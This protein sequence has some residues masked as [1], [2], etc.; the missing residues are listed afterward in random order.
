MKNTSVLVVLL[1][2]VHHQ[3]KQELLEQTLTTTQ[4][5]LSTKVGEIVRLEQSQ[6]SLNTELKTVKDRVVSC[7]DEIANQNQTIGNDTFY[8]YVSYSVQCSHG[9]NSAGSREIRS[10]TSIL[11]S[12]ISVWRYG[13]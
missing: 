2:L 9:L 3:E 8:V 5:Q 1:Q 4:D 12:G 13:T 7:D 11:R 6:R 10:G